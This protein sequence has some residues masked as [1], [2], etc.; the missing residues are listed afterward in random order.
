MPRKLKSLAK[1]SQATYYKAQGKFIPTKTLHFQMKCKAEINRPYGYSGDI[2]LQTP[3]TIP[4]LEM[5]S[6]YGR[7]IIK[8]DHSLKSLTGSG[9]KYFPMRLRIEN[10][11]AKVQ[12]KGPK[13]N[14]PYGLALEFELIPNHPLTEHLNSQEV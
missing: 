5:I 9:L 6:N 10:N 8:L 7:Y 2:Y 4:E 1:D 13:A 12:I 14:R 11:I 3:P